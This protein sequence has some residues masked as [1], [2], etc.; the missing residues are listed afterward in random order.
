MGNVFTNASDIW[1]SALRFRQQDRAGC[2]DLTGGKPT[3]PV[4]STGEIGSCTFNYF[5][6]AMGLGLRYHTPVGPVRVDFSWNVNPP[7]YPVTLNS[8][9]N[10]PLAVPY[11]GEGSHFN[12]FFSLGQSF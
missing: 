11:V 3:G 12:F 1:P 8:T 7:I 5:S 4:Y 9:D 6:H 2:R 10:T